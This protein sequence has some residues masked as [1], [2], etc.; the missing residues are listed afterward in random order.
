M[1]DGTSAWHL[2]PDGDWVRHDRD[3]AGHLLVDLQDETWRQVS[4]RRRTGGAR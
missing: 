3:A 1:D 4:S 2:Q